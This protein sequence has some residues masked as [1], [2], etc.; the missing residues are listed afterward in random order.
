MT[1]VMLSRGALRF[2]NGLVRTCPLEVCDADPDGYVEA[3]RQLAA[4]V[5][6]TEDGE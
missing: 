6:D 2:L 4:A 3:K 1:A 5:D